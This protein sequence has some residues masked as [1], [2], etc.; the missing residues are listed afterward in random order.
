MRQY[1]RYKVIIRC[2]GSTLFG[3]GKK[4]LSN[5]M[6]VSVVPNQQGVAVAG[7]RRD[8]DVPPALELADFQSSGEHGIDIRKLV[9]AHDL[10]TALCVSILELGSYSLLQVEA[11]DVQQD[12][13]KAAIRWKVK[14]LLDYH[15]DDAVFDVFEIPDDKA[16]GRN[17]R[18]YVVAARSAQVKQRIDYL[19]E[20]GLNL[21]VIDI[22]ELALRNIAALLPEDVNGV[23]LVYIDQNQGLITVTRQETLYLSRHLR[24]GY[25]SLPDTAIHSHDQEALDTWLD[26]IIIEVQRSLDYY[27]SH[28]SQPHVSGLVITPGV[29]DIPGMTEYLSQQLAI[30]VR[31]LVVN[32]LIDTSIAIDQ[33]LQSHCLLAIG[34]ALRHESM[35]L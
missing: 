24:F 21:E 28:F 20:A 32:E 33:Q 34:A 22:P 8:K 30:P 17:K 26:G 16:T 5:D 23:A 6:L 7:I 18:M 10:D 13:L 29:R 1:F 11:P 35:T 4:R 19:V 31:Y 15:I 14:D 12:E 3:L 27:E 9:R 2:W 25:D